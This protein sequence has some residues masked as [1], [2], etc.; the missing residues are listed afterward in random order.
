M[1]H[2]VA[3]IREATVAGIVNLD[4]GNEAQEVPPARALG[5]EASDEEPSDPTSY[6]RFV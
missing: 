4:S 5:D 1:P 3:F 2:H 6:L